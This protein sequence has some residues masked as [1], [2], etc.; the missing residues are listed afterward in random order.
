MGGSHD[1]AKFMVIVLRNDALTKP[2]EQTSCAMRVGCS[3]CLCRNPQNHRQPEPWE[4][5]RVLKSS[6]RADQYFRRD[7]QHFWFSVYSPVDDFVDGQ[8]LRVPQ[9]G[10]P[11]LTAE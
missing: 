2:F 8:I 7:E 4:R 11:R 1:T 6:A 3:T 10:R 5:T 9:C